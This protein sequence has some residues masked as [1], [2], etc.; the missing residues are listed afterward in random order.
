VLL[1]SC[2]YTWRQVADLVGVPAGTVAEWLRDGL[3][4]LNS[5]DA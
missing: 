1:A 3:L 2:G 5:R 4:E